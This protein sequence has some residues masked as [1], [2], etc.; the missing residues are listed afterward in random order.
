MAVVGAAP[1]DDN[2]GKGSMSTLVSFPG[3]GKYLFSTDFNRNIRISEY[4]PKNLPATTTT[5]NFWFG[6][7]RDHSYLESIHQPG[8][9]P[10]H[11]ASKCI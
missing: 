10:R 7:F 4:N 5:L 3:G 6:I 1:G 11:L 8:L 2:D 9:R